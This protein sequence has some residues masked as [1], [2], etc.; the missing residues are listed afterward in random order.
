M[1]DPDIT[2]EEYIRLEE[3]KARRHARNFNW[4]IATYGCHSE[5]DI[6]IPLEDILINSLND[7]IDNNTDPNEL[8][9]NVT[10]NT[11][12]V[13]NDVS[14]AYGFL[15]LLDTSPKEKLISYTDEPMY[16]FLLIKSSGPHLDH[17]DL[18]QLDG[19]DIE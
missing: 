16:S 15:L 6:G 1:D 14:T 9:K 2:I 10:A 17:E 7:V 12:A 13:L 4:E 8:D 19:V 5:I 11:L 3:E 18:N